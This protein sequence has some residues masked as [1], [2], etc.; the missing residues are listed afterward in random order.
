VLAEYF[1]DQAIV[2]GDNL[3]QVASQT[4]D[5]LSVIGQAS[6]I[7]VLRPLLAYD[8]INIMDLAQDIGTY[9][10][11]SENVPDSC[12]VFASNNP[13]TRAKPDHISHEEQ[14]IPL[15]ELLFQCLDSASLINAQNCHEH[16]FPELKTY[17]QSLQN[18]T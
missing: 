8:K 15:R 4:L 6:D 1:Q 12:T 18:F 2:T 14:K 16:P 3:G 11:S 5:N 9:D 10:I 7:L 17:S 13:A